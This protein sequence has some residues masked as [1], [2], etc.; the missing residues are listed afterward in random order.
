MSRRGA[1]PA[2]LLGPIGKVSFVVGV[3]LTVLLAVYAVDY[4]SLQVGLAFMASFALL[5][6]G[7]IVGTRYQGKI[8]ARR[9]SAARGESNLLW[10]LVLLGVFAFADFFIPLAFG[11]FASGKYL[12]TLG[13][14]AFIQVG[15]ILVI[16]NGISESFFFPYGLGNFYASLQSKGMAGGTGFAIILTSLSADAYHLAVYPGIISLAVV[17]VAFAA[18]TWVGFRTGRLWPVILAHVLNNAAVF[19]LSVLALSH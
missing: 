17:F 9:Q 15:A 12:S 14:A 18:M 16:V 6:G 2:I 1:R 11:F 7:F 10:A 19:G 13:L 5:V 8:A 4:D 3:L